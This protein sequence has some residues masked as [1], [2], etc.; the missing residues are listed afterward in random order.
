MLRV[1]CRVVN[2]TVLGVEIEI[3][4]G[5]LRRDNSGETGK[6]WVADRSRGQPLIE[7]GVIRRHKLAITKKWDWPPLFLGP[8]HVLDRGIYLKGPTLGKTLLEDTGND[9]FLSIGQ[10]FALDN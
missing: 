3:I 5:G 6:T 7:I 1:S 2:T 9:W 8:E 4:R 10:G